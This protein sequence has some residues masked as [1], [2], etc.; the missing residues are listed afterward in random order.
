M[1]N[2]F[3]YSPDRTIPCKR[4]ITIYPNYVTKEYINISD[5]YINRIIKAS[6]FLNHKK[7]G[8]TI[9]EIKRDNKFLIIKMEKLLEVEDINEEKMINI[10][11]ILHD[12]DWCHGDLHS[13][14]IMNNKN[15]ELRII[16]FDTMFR[17]SRG[18][19]DKRV[20]KYILYTNYKNYLEFITKDDFEN[21]TKY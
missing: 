11:N 9:Y 2:Q 3:I 8:P 20:L 18:K 21:W 5:Y 13:K 15:K 4:I 10:V 12:N 14:N 19:N 17:I 6:L 1:E 7:V 16:D